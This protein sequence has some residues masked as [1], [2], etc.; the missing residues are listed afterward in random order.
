MRKCNRTLI[1]RGSVKRRA[2]HPVGFATPDEFRHNELL[3]GFAD[4]AWIFGQHDRPNWNG[5]S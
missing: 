5:R 4:F 3:S 2:I 1:V